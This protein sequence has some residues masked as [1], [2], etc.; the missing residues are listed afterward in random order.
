MFYLEHLLAN[1]S[2]STAVTIKMMPESGKF[3]LKV[4]SRWID[5]PCFNVM[6]N[7][8]F[9]NNGNNYFV[10]IADTMWRADLL[11]PIKFYFEIVLLTNT[12]RVSGFD[13]VIDFLVCSDGGIFNNADQTF[14]A[15]AMVNQQLCDDRITKQV[16]TT[17]QLSDILNMCKLERVIVSRWEHEMVDDYREQETEVVEDLK[18]IKDIYRAS[19]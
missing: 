16:K 19:Q 15:I 10:M 4:R 13:P 5:A 11:L 14:D 2:G 18:T 12:R 3:N 9:E 8:H 17:N 6:I 1:G 7:G